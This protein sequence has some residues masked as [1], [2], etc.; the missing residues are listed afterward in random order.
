MKPANLVVTALL[1]L[2]A[3]AHVLRLIFGTQVTVAGRTIPMWASAAA[4][5]LF[6]ALAI[7]LWRENA[8]AGKAAV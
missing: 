7:G 1:L 3:I 8:A 2:I 5:I 6:A 4:A